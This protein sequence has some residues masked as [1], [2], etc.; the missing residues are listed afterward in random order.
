MGII[1]V[2]ATKGGWDTLLDYYV[3]ISVEDNEDGGAICVIR[4][5]FSIR[6]SAVDTANEFALA[7]D[8]TIEKDKSLV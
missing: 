7:C 2:K 8:P 6:R 5:P 3:D 1:K 4:I